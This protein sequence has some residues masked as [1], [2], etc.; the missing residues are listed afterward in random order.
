MADLKMDKAAELKKAEETKANRV[1]VT[2]KGLNLNDFAEDTGLSIPSIK[3]LKVPHLSHTLPNLPKYKNTFVRTK[4]GK[5][6]TQLSYNTMVKD[7]EYVLFDVVRSKVEPIFAMERA[8]PRPV[9]VWAPGEVK[10]AIVTCGGLCPGLNAVVCELVKMLCW[11]YGVDDVYGIRMGYRGFYDPAW[12]PYLRLTPQVVDGLHEQG[13]TI[14]GSSRGGF[15]QKKIVDALIQHG[16][17]QVYVVGG[18]GTQRAANKLH[19]EVASRKLKIAVVGIPKTID[20]DIGFI[21]K[22]FGFDT[23]V[24]EAEKAIKSARVEAR[25]TPNGIGI[26]KVMGRH[27][28]FIAAH[29]S[30]ASRDVDLVLIPEIKFDFQGP[31]G[32]LPHIERSLQR[33]GSCVVV[34]AEG[35]GDFLFEGKDLGRDASGNKILPDVTGLLRSEIKKYFQARQMEITI[36]Y[37]DPSYMI[38]SVAANPIDGVYCLILSHNAVHAAFAGYTGVVSGLVNTR[39]VLLPMDVLCKA[40]PTFLNPLGRTWERVI[41]STHQPCASFQL[42]S[43]L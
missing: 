35:A 1:G 10:A 2:E 17:N 15:D 19:Q 11:N 21:D 5:V 22:S 36:K 42:H 12:L 30:L 24:T 33:Q 20:N 41:S 39:T 8:G 43:R 27:A 16:I 28:G 7:K 9:S 26:V 34:V 37:N 6:Q 4:L 29:A 14:L 38:R 32:I 18:D 23:A 40:S 25:C 31:D 13:G 3:V